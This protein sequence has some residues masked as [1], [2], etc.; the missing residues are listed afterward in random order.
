M[1]SVL[2]KRTNLI[3][4]MTPVDLGTIT[5]ETQSFF[6]LNTLYFCFLSGEYH[7]DGIILTKNIFCIHVSE[8][9][10]NVKGDD[11]WIKNF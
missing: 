7:P 9:K 6:S 5:L 3:D 4:W 1:I 11:H 10:P 2:G 8:L